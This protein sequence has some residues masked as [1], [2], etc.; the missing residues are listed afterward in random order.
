MNIVKL[1][2]IL[3]H[4]Y[5][6]STTISYTELYLERSMVTII[7]IYHNILV[8]IYSLSL[9]NQLQQV[10][11]FKSQTQFKSR[12]S[13]VNHYFVILLKLFK[14]GSWIKLIKL[15]K[16]LVDKMS[17]QLLQNYSLLPNKQKASKVFLL[18]LK[19]TTIF[20]RY[21][22][23]RIWSQ[24]AWVA[25]RHPCQSPEGTELLRILQGTQHRHERLEA[26]T[27]NHALVRKLCYWPPPS[28][29]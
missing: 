27:R 24:C 16:V 2:S 8:W 7:M 15:D 12:P 13:F 4:K 23:T 20:F 17:A 1:I 6:G 10:G 14:T 19:L 29:W 3:R 25:G 5:L 21:G 9:S 11:T 18:N 26:Q 28:Y 22:K